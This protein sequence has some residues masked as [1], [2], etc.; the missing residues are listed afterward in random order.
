MKIPKKKWLYIGIESK[1]REYIAK[2]FLSI[3]SL[4]Y[5]FNVV[6]GHHSA[7]IYE[8]FSIMPKGVYMDNSIWNIQ[9]DKFTK[10]KTKGHKICAIDEEGLVYRNPDVLLDRVSPK[11][12]KLIDLFFA[13]GQ[14]Q[15]EIISKKYP[16]FK[17]K[18]KI[19]GNPRIDILREKYYDLYE[20]EI[21]YIREK[22]GRY[23]LVNSNFPDGTTNTANEK[24]QEMQK[25]T[26]NIENKQENYYKNLI[27]Y[28]KK[29]VNYF[30]KAIKNLA[31]STKLNI[32]IRPHPSENSDFWFKAFKNFQNV[33]CVYK[34]S[35]NPWIIESEIL[36]H[37]GCT[38]AIEAFLMNKAA[39]SYRPIKS[40][41]YDQ[42]LPNSVSKE[43]NSVEDLKKW[44]FIFLNNKEK[45]KES[46]E[47]KINVI[48]RI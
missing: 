44:L 38:T 24:F 28:Q 35:A 9:I 47:Q 3:I 33:K 7:R 43:V 27:L 26:K 41:L 16:N 22:Y 31:E 37:N 18:I 25:L 29:L 45:S 40:N 32:I 30:V 10:L 39:I 42:E 20:K 23:I 8:N 4:K 12:L 19:V 48:K 2:L 46:Y 36:I 15:A 1:S 14:K 34:F 21:K 17:R 6:L 13:W 5:D 11:C